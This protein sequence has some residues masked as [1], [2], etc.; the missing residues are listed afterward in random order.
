MPSFKGQ[1]F[2]K[3]PHAGTSIFAI[4][5]KMAADFK[6]VNLSQGF[7]DF[8]ISEKLIARVNH[9]MKKG[10]NQYAPMPGV[11]SLRKAIGKK[12]ETTYGVRYSPDTEITVTAGA[13]QALYTAISTFVKDSDEVIIFEPAYDSYA[14]AVKANGGLVK[15]AEL[16]APFFKIDWNSVKRMVSNRTRMIIINSPHNPTGSLL[17]AEDMQQLEMLTSNTDIIVLSDEVYEHLIFDGIPHQSVCLYPELLSRSFVIGSFGKTFHA[18]GWKTGFVLAPEELTKEFR[19]LHQFVVFAANTPIQHAIADFIADPEN[20]SGLPSFYQAKRDYFVSGL[21][22][23]RFKIIPCYGTYFQLLDYSAISDESEMAFAERLVKENGIA[24]IPVAPFYHNQ[25][26]QQLIRVC[27]AKTE[28]T[29]AKAT[30]ILCR[31]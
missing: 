30:E 31:I 22:Q 1:V 12:V 19:K 9:Y 10:F 16:K 20:Y 8:P 13:T 21:A 23:S 29:L 11:E 17:T 25:L 28:E 24:V 3:L 14:P 26:N 4:M 27:F 15:Y 18:T 6:A 5:S 2:S 7:P